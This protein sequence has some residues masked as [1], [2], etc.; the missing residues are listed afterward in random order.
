MTDI[1]YGLTQEEVQ[2]RRSLGQDNHLIEYKTK[3]VK[4]ILIDNLCTFFNMIN[5]ILGLFILTTG[6]YKN[7]LFLGVIVC[8]IIIGIA[9]ELRAK[10]SLDKINLITRTKVFVQREGKKQECYPYLSNS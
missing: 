3:S 9:V 4:Q 8:N 5:F 6:S 2:K 1:K 7:L 10:R